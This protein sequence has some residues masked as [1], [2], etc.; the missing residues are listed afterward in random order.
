MQK[1]YPF[2]VAVIADWGPIIVKPYKPLN[3]TLDYI[4]KQRVL[5][6]TTRTGT[7][8]RVNSLFINGDYAYNLETDHCQMYLLFL[9]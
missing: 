3:N 7:E 4:L 1:D 8:W 2:R 9:N 5:E 6:R